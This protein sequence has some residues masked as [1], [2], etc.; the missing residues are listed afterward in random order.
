ME[1]AEFVFSFD[2]KRKKHLMV[3]VD[4]LVEEEKQNDRE[5]VLNGRLKKK[6]W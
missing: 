2:G 6:G 4:K 5:V 3:L 1:N